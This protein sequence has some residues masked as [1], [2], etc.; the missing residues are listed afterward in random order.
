MDVCGCRH[1]WTSK[2]DLTKNMGV[3]WDVSSGKEKA[4]NGSSVYDV[5]EGM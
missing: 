2:L 5:L 4:R 3:D 1:S